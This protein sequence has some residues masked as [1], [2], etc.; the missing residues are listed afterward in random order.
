MHS[1]CRVGP[2]S[3]DTLQG[4]PWGLQLQRKRGSYNGWVD[5][6]WVRKSPSAVCKE[7]K[8][9]V[10]GEAQLCLNNETHRVTKGPSLQGAGVT[11]FSSLRRTLARSHLGSCYLVPRGF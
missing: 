8:A 10:G 6:V 5:A 11:S 9:N 7:E 4:G 2:L 1:A 3:F